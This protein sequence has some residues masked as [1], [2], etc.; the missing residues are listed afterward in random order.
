MIIER[1]RFF[2]S[3]VAPKPEEVDYWIDLTANVYGGVIKYYNGY[4]WIKLDQESISEDYIRLRNKPILNGVT[5]EG[6][7]TSADYGIPSQEDIDKTI[8]EV[9]DTVT[10][11][12]KTV[13]EVID[14]LTGT[15]TEI[16]K[17]EEDITNINNVL[18]TIVGDSASNVIDKFNEILNFLTGYTDQ[19]TLE[20]ILNDLQAEFNTLIQGIEDDIDL[21]EKSLTAEINAVQE[22]LDN[23]KLDYN[24][25]HK[26]TKA[27]VGLSNVDNTSDIN[28]PVST[29]QQAAI[30]AVDA[31]LETH[32]TDYTNPHKVTKTQVGLTYVDN[33]SDL[34]KPISNA[35][36]AALDEE[37]AARQELREEVMGLITGTASGYIPVDEKGIANGV[38]TLNENGLIPTD[39][40]PSYVDDVIDVYAV[41]TKNDDGSFSN[42]QLYSDSSHQQPITGESGKIYIDITSDTNNLQFRWSGT[43]FAVI[44]GST[45]IGEVTGTA[46]DGGKGKALNDLVTIING[47]DTTEGSFKKADADVLQAAKDYTD[48]ELSNIEIPSSNFIITESD[49]ANNIMPEDRLNLLNQAIANNSIICISLSD[50]FITLAYSVN[51]DNIAEFTNAVS[52]VS[53]SNSVYFIGVTFKINL[54]SGEVNIGDTVLNQFVFYKDSTKDN[55][56]LSGDGSYKEITQP[57]LATT[58]S[59][60]LMPELEGDITYYLNGAGQWTKTLAGQYLMCNRTWASVDLILDSH[61]YGNIGSGQDGIYVRATNDLYLAPKSTVFTDN[62]TPTTG[63]IVKQNNIEPISSEILYNIGADTNRFQDLY[64]KGNA[65]ITGTARCSGVMITDSTNDY[66]VL[67][68]GGVKALSEIKTREYASLEIVGSN[69]DGSEPNGYI[70]FSYGGDNSMN[71]QYRIMANSSELAIKCYSENNKPDQIVFSVTADKYIYIG[72]DTNNFGISTNDTSCIKNGGHTLVFNGRGGYC[73][74]KYYFLGGNSS[75]GS[76]NADLYIGNCKAV[77]GVISIADD[78]MIKHSFLSNGNASHTGSVSAA[79]GFYDTSDIRLKTNISEINNTSE[80]KLVQ[81]DWISSGKHSYGAIAQDVEKN[82]PELISEMEDDGQIYKTINYDALLCL[83]VAQLENKIKSLQKELE[84]L[85][86]G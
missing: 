59:P 34:N 19:Q 81:F 67:A 56:F 78:V 82:Y 37:A 18:E 62:V 63:L 68:G 69:Q 66:V 47:S 31:D 32:I 9:R 20:D 40:L 65:Y 8:Q 33:T 60:G 80:I 58:S 5:I 55:L 24:N 86:N 75:Q 73:H 28:K 77:D 36:Q 38:A 61:Y 72:N 17:I 27:Q 45:I 85:K 79:S 50:M 48:Q 15:E 10:E 74:K 4:D 84:D 16:T 71:F 13:Q 2:A 57:E 35:T 53:N 3:Y 11:L 76:T 30:D 46:Y 1:V 21:A 6:D 43:E 26:V 25:P 39:Q 51:S 12:D 23:H 29:A 14:N 42:I 64:L 83:K 49:I 44:T 52:D 22:A 41:Y 70:D 54:T 7:K